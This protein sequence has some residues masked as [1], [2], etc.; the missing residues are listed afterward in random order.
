MNYAREEDF[1]ALVNAGYNLTDRIGVARYGKMFRGTKA[2]IG[3]NFGLTGLVI[4]PACGL[5]VTI[6]TVVAH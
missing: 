4:W 6:Y 3:A 5:S 2:Q 1:Q